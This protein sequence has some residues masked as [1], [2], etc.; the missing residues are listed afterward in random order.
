MDPKETLGA[1]SSD[2]QLREAEVTDSNMRNH[3]KRVAMRHLESEGCMAGGALHLSVTWLAN[4]H[5]RLSFVV[6]ASNS[7]GSKKR[8]GWNNWAAR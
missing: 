8:W 5:P 2:P 4:R 6:R 1:H 3:Q 7:S